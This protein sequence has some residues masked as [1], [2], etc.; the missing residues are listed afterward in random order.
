MKLSN[1]LGLLQPLPIPHR[2]WYS[3]SMDF[4][5]GLPNS[6]KQN[7]I[8]VIVVRLTKYVHFFSLAHPY[9]AAKVASLFMQNIFKLHGLPSSIVSDRDIAFTSTFWQELFTRQGIDLAMSIAY[10]PQ[11]D[12]QTEVVNRSLEQYLKPLQQ[13]NPTTPFEALYGY[14]PPRLL[15]YIPDTTQ[16]EAVD[17]Y[18]YIRQQALSLLKTNLVAAQERMKLQANKNRIEKEFQV[19]DWVYLRLQPFKQRSMHQ[20][21]GKLAPRFYGPY[22]ILERIGAVAYKLDLPNDALIHPVFHVSCLK[23]KLG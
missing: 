18:L 2:P 5:E 4:I 10:H 23:A 7:V 20:K 13:T 17:N 1:Q 16:V 21:M 9:T 3:I 19:G 12:G 11:T 22:Q 14:P 6:N 15:E 8:L